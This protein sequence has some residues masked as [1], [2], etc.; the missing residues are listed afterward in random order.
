MKLSKTAAQAALAV[1][2]LATCDAARPTQAR[3]IAEYLGVPTDSALKILQTLA[4]HR[5]IRSQLG[6][7]GGYR[8]QQDPHDVTLL[9]VIEAV[10]GPIMAD[11]ALP[12]SV[13][14]A[15]Y[16]ADVLRQMCETAVTDIRRA[17]SSTTMADLLPS[18]AD[19]L[20]ANEPQAETP[21]SPLVEYAQASQA[22]VTTGQPDSA[23][24]SQAA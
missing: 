1:A 8:L 13:G 18:E 19:S 7:S 5:I 20:S 15:R 10:E 17:L 24:Q 12:P 4:R 22:P 23:Q 14:S 16:A 21:T 11:V 2:Y 9:A 3:Q 6:R